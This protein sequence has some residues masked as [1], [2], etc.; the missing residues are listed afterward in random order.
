MHAVRRVLTTA[1][2]AGVLAMA[3]AGTG[4]AADATPSPDPSATASPTASPD[5]DATPSPAP[6]EEPLP[7]PTGGGCEENPVICESNAGSGNP[8]SADCEQV[9]EG[10][11]AS[12]PPDGV[13][14]ITTAN[15][16]EVTPVSAG[17]GEGAAVPETLPRTGP[18][19]VLPTLAV[20]SWLLLLGV[21]ASI[22]ARRRTA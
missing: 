12:P 7:E 3:S 10:G 17:A 5:P 13:F 16:G 19:P 22:A 6:S 21:L 11:V 9:Q 8:G 20:G 18:A 2:L 14:C 1:G 15:P 4:W